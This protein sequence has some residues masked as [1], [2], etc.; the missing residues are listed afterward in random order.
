MWY[1][2]FAHKLL[3]PTFL[4]YVKHSITYNIP[5]LFLFKQINK[6]DASACWRPYGTEN[7]NC[8]FANIQLHRLV[9]KVYHEYEFQIHVNEYAINE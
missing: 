3:W 8:H 4:G 1:F 9:L 2:L 6:Q 5:I 7:E